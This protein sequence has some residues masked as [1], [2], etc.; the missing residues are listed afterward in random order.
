MGKH[1]LSA[2]KVT[3]DYQE[4]KGVACVAMTRSQYEVERR[5]HNMQNAI[6]SVHE[7]YTIDT[8]RKC[9]AKEL[10]SA[11]EDLM[12]ASETYYYLVEGEKRSEKVLVL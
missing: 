5:L 6:F 4:L 3:L 10:Y 9:E 12:H 7:P 2:D 8:I 11:A 1:D